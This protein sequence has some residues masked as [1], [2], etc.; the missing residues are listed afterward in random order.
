MA[1]VERLRESVSNP[2]T[3]EEIQQKAADGWRLV[4]VEWQREVAAGSGPAEASAAGAQTPYGLR[5]GD[6]ETDLE[7]DPRE[8]EALELM[9]GLVI[10][11]NNSLAEVAEELN[12]RGFRTRSGDSWSQV[13]VFNMLPRLVEV[14]PEIFAGADWKAQ[15]A[16][17]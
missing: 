1:R 13:T 16:T 12:R 2:P 7:S 14:A 17:N 5:T 6:G 9:L 10:D 15:A 11:D 3:A 4:A 8:A